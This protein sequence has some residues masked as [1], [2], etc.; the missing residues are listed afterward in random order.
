[1]PVKKWE[2]DLAYSFLILESSGAAT[3]T[4]DILNLTDIQAVT[5]GTVADP[6]SSSFSLKLYLI[7]GISFLVRYQGEG[8]NAGFL[9]L[10]KTPV[11]A[12]PT[13][14]PGP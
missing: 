8:G 13:D 12:G 9:T 4:L 3:G 10:W 5:Y 2:L 7:S 14:N 6:S 11:P 1:M